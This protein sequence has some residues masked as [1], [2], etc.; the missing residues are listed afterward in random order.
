MAQ[1]DT[2]VALVLVSAIR[3]DSPSRTHAQ[4]VIVLDSFSVG[5]TANSR[6]FSLMKNLKVRDR[7]TRSPTP[8]TAHGEQREPLMPQ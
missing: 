2:L 8:E 5:L 4:L 3:T 6:E 7:E 1:G